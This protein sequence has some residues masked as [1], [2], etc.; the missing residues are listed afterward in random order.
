M[1]LELSKRFSKN[2]QTSN[3]LT[4]HPVGAQLIHADAW[5]DRLR[6]GDTANLIVAFR[7]FAHGL[8]ATLVSV[9]DPMRNVSLMFF[10]GRTELVT[11]VKTGSRK[12]S[13]HTP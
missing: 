12:G 11:L 4:I 5:T 7:N 2:T 9:T 8:K 13:T 6:H 3:F 1:K 10:P